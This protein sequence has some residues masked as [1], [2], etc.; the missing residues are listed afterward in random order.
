MELKE[1]TANITSQYGEDG[2]I[3]RLL[4]IIGDNVEKTCVEFGA[5]D[6]EHLSNTW[7][8]INN[9]GWTG[10]YIEGNY[11][12]YKKLKQKYIGNPKVTCINAMVGDAS[13]R[14][15]TLNSILDSCSFKKRIGLLS[16]DIDGNDYNVWRDFVGYDVDIVCIEYN[17][18]FPPNVLHIDNGGKEFIGS[19]ALS[20]TQLANAKGYELVACTFSNCIYVKKSLFPFLNISNNSVEALMPIDGITHVY[21][22][23]AG[24]L[25]FSN[26]KIVDPIVAAVI[27]KSPRKLFKL[28]I[29]RLRSFRF[30]GQAYPD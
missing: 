22:N 3:Q 14:G 7:N 23:F 1:Y 19:S 5:W 16:I 10:C 21:R 6:G 17:P 4:E 15:G 20:L 12:R 27:Y 26:R 29:K 13:A 8:L 18:T 11:S 24:E 9:H 28:L 30:I 25:V 2:V